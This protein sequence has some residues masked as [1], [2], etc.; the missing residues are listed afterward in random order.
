MGRYKRLLSNTAILGAGT[1][2]SKVLVFLLMPFYT[3][4]LS[5]SE[6]GTADIISQ[7]ANL[8][9]PLASV[10]ICDGLFRFTLD[11]QK[12]DKK[13]VFSSAVAVLV[14]GSAATLV[15]VQIFQLFD[16][17]KGYVTVL[18]LYVICANFHLA[19]ANYLRAQ[20]RTATFALQ[21]IIN[22]ALTIA[23]NVLF[24]LAFDMGSL[25]YVLSVVVAD[26]LV[27]LGIVLFCK[28]YKDINFRLVDKAT[29]KSM[30]KFSIPYIPTTMMWLITSVSDRYIVTAFEGTDVNGLYAASY[31][32]PTLVSLASGVFIEAWQLSSVKDSLPEERASFFEN[33]YKN[34]M[35]LM[36]MGASVIVAG[37]QIFT[38]LLLAD[39]Y[40]VS[41]KY[42]PILVIATTFSAL[43][44]FLGSVYFVEKKSMLSML[45]AMS[46]AIIN[47]IL[48][49]VLIPTHGAMGAAVATLISYVAVYVIRATDIGIYVKFKLHYLRVVVNT[50]ALW[51]QG[52]IMIEGIPYWKYMQ[53]ALLLF[54]LAFNGRGIVQSILQI[55]SKKV[56]KI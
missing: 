47:V 2:A 44:A 7:T 11:A 42:V 30:L 53:I 8:L 32:I 14:I 31:K 52:I 39:S 23:L 55:F 51:V 49:F 18:A 34:Y 22:T 16:V 41:W 3:A 21:G 33:V 25:G 48:N 35:S 45:T 46:G 43:S 27:T 15:F 28:L 24:L 4:I 50:G 10:G 9:I 5:T 56:K 54:M 12:E 37:S 19:A 29:L 17:F 1:F 40:Y 38:K 36:F 26:F 6:F 13:R 20:G